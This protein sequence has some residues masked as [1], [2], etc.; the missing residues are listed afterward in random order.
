MVSIK[1]IAE[2]CGVSIATVSKALNNHSDVGAATKKL[3]CDTAKRLG[4][5]P[6]AQARALKTNKT[7]NI[8]VLLDDK[9]KS[10]LTHCF[11]S[12]VLDGFRVEAEKQ[13]YD[14]TFIGGQIGGSEMSCYEH[15]IYRR[16]DGVLAA[17]VDFYGNEVRELMD[18]EIPL[19]SIDFKSEDH[20][21]VSSDNSEGIRTLVNYAYECG[22]TKIAYIYGDS[23][24]VTTIRLNSYLD[25]MKELGLQVQPD[26][27]KQGKHLDTVIT[28]KLTLEMLGLY[29]PPT[30]ILVPDDLAAIGS[31]NAAK[32]VGK[33]VP[34]DISIA[35]YDGIQMTQLITPSLTTFSQN[36]YEIGRA[37]ADLLIK[38]I[39]KEEI[40]ENQRNIEISGHL[41]KGNT[42]K[43][44]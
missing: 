12:A 20:Y 32:E 25:T 28:Q 2:E 3:V 6:N 40:P 30:C 21:S 34:D 18:S 14:I 11:F 36:T 17:C 23:S 29:D 43:H 15:C 1:T 38:I 33:T 35:G 22:H 8:G 42:V 16:V 41:I 4:Y 24:Q 13:G 10:G 39:K 44:I 31:L 7:Y 9:A 19:V 37:A 5:F 27:L 26:Y